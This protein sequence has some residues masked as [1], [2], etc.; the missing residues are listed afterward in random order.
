MN[1]KALVKSIFF[2]GTLIGFDALLKMTGV[3]SNAM[4]VV[5]LSILF[6]LS[7]VSFYL[8]FDDSSEIKT[9][10]KDEVGNNV[11]DKKLNEVEKIA[12]FLD[13][14]NKDYE[15][16]L[17]IDLK[18]KL[19]FVSQKIKN[20]IT[21][22][23]FYDMANDFDN[24]L[25]IKNIATKY[26]KQSLDNYVNVQE[27]AKKVGKNNK[28]AELMMLEQ[29]ST[30]ENQLDGIIESLTEKDINKMKMYSKFLNERFNTSGNSMFSV[31]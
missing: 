28:D 5:E 10:L 24:F 20:I 31:E 4:G 2:S 15:K 29:L 13:E 23:Q 27:L 17:S 25:I 18:T 11:D 26:L 1:K 7:G 19:F 9:M 21:V 12:L 8:N 22:R 30:M 6:V 16:R 14:L 3:L